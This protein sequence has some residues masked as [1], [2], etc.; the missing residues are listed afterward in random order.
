MRL[1]FCYGDWLEEDA[2]LY[3]RQVEAD[4]REGGLLCECWKRSGPICEG[5][6]R[7][8]EAVKGW[9]REGG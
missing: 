2:R 1:G 6:R 9:G 8:A 3:R 7:R 5:C 4:R